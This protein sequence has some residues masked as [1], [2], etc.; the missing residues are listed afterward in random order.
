MRQGCGSSTAGIPE[1]GLPKA[2]PHSP[3][4]ARAP[5]RGGS[6]WGCSGA[7]CPGAEPG[8]LCQHPG[9]PNWSHLGIATPGLADKP[10]LLKLFGGPA[11]QRQLSISQKLPA[12]CPKGLRSPLCHSDQHL[13]HEGPAQLKEGPGEGW[14]KKLQLLLAFLF[15]SY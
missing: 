8:L 10:V 2:L 9:T 15:L 5:R 6:S 4:M 13:G 7:V 11:R 1:P 12:P 3:A 14:G